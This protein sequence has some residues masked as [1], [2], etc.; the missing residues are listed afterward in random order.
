MAET[1]A[2]PAAAYAGTENGISVG[3]LSGTNTNDATYQHAQVHQKL[4]AEIIASE[5][6]IGFGASNQTPVTNS[7]LAGTGA[8]ASSWSTTPTLVDLTLTGDLVV[9]DDTTIT[10]LLAVTETATIT[11][12]TRA[13]AGLVVADA[14]SLPATATKLYIADSD[15]GAE[16]RIDSTI[17]GT[18]YG[19][20]IGADANEPYV[21]SRTAH[22]FRFITTN[23][24]RA[25]ITDAGVFQIKTGNTFEVYG[26]GDVKKVSLIHN[27]TDGVLTSSSGAMILSAATHVRTGSGIEMRMYESG[28]TNYTG[29]SHNTTNAIWFT[30]TGYNVAQ[31][32]SL[33][34]VPATDNAYT[35]GKT[36]NRWTEVWAANGTIQTSDI[37]LKDVMDVSVLG[38][39]FI[40]ALKPIAYTWKSE[41]KRVDVDGAM[42]D[43][44]GDI[45]LNED[46][47]EIITQ[48]IE[49]VEKQEEEKLM[50]Y[51]FSAQAVESTLQQMG[52]DPR[53]F[54]GTFYDEEADQ[55][56]LNYQQ[57][58]LPI[59][60]AFQELEARV[61]TLET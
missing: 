8:G 27:D 10:G 61:K 34:L 30:S 17:S 32:G 33:G 22:D 4:A 55:Y 7:V 52:V 25:R 29:I 56:N 42:K 43:V 19:I 59:V 58:I 35:L 16:M 54:G 13:I 48:Q 18:T 36:G 47:N 49:L 12:L 44:N 21:G 5:T 14:T 41:K 57:F 2:F 9:G 6:K 50:Y 40:L 15:S 1:A 37:R 24:E 28:N 38:T 46:G 23:V 60:K 39:E 26:A 51:G 31:G 45:V 11:G 3:A 53:A 20:S